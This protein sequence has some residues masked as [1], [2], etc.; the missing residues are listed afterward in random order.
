MSLDGRRT[1]HAWLWRRQG[2]QRA[3]TLSAAAAGRAFAFELIGIGLLGLFAGGAAGSIW[4]AFIGWFL[5]QAVQSAAASA[6]TRHVLGGH[7]VSDAMAW[8]PLTVPADLVVADSPVSNDSSTCRA[9]VLISRRSAGIRT[10][11]SSSTTSPGT[12]SRLSIS[13]SRPSRMTRAWGTTSCISARTAPSAFRSWVKPITALSTSTAAITDA[14]RYS[15]SSNVT[16]SARSRMKINGLRNW[17]RSTNH[18]GAGG[19]SPSWFG[20]Y[21]ASRA[22]ASCW[23]SP[24]LPVSSRCSTSARSKRCQAV[25]TSIAGRCA[26]VVVPGRICTANQRR[27]RLPRADGHNR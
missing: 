22:S 6:T 18:G 8:A 9:V 25:S 20:P 16:A 24:C 21:R 2:N 17:R 1:L 14:S 5:L 15:P 12:R 3:A 23:T 4:I 7:R 26:R 13:R 27:P 10:P 11:D 19:S